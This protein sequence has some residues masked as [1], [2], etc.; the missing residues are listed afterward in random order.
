MR[1]LVTAGRQN[2]SVG[3]A[4]EV[5]LLENLSITAGDNTNALA[6]DGVNLYALNVYCASADITLKIYKG[7]GTNAGLRPAY[8][9]TVSAG[10]SYSYEF[11]GNAMEY[12]AVTG[13]TA[14]GTAT[15]SADFR[16]K[17]FP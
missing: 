2:V 14:A 8:S 7:A 5:N 16:G 3:S 13:Q 4:S 15:V 10:A 1:V 17:S 12:I 11:V 9:T 6:I